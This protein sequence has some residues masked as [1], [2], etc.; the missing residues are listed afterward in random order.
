MFAVVVVVPA[1]NTDSINSSN[2]ITS[3]VLNITYW[4]FI[5]KKVVLIVVAQYATNIHAHT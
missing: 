5:V 4:Y 1:V 3:W 2:S